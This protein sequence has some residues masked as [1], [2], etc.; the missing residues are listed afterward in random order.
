MYEDFIKGTI[1]SDERDKTTPDMD[2]KR[3]AFYDVRIFS[4]Y[5]KTV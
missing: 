1:D 2:P 5:H 4:L 3:A